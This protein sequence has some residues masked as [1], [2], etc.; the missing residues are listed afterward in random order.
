ITKENGIALIWPPQCTHMEMRR[1]L[2]GWRSEVAL[3]PVCLGSLI[4][5]WQVVSGIFRD[6]CVAERTECSHQLRRAGEILYCY[7]HIDDIFCRQSWHR[8]RTDVIDTS[9]QF[10]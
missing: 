5:R 9:R 2:I 3:L 7:L 10:S 1:T 4:E 8:C 6:Q